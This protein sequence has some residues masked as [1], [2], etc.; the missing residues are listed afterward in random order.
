MKSKFENDM[1]L[2]IMRS[3]MIASKGEEGFLGIKFLF[4]TGVFLFLLVVFFPAAFVWFIIC[5]ALA[6]N[7]RSNRSRI[8]AARIVADTRRQTR[9]VYVTDDR[10]RDEYHRR[11][12]Y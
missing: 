12:E 5:T 2:K 1:Q 10:Y 11:R 8:R 9:D 7:E 4:S 3:A 6:L